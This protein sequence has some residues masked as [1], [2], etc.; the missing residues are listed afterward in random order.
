[1]TSPTFLRN[2]VAAVLV[3]VVSLTAGCTATRRPVGNPSPS[4]SPS[5]TSLLLADLDQQSRSTGWGP[6]D[7][8]NILFVSDSSIIPGLRY[9]WGVLSPQRAMHVYFTAVVAT[10]EGSPVSVVIRSAAD[11]A[12]ATIGFVPSS[13]TQALEACAEGV[14]VTDR[15]RVPRAKPRVYLGPESLRNLP[16]AIGASNLSS[17]RLAAPLVGRDGA[18]GWR[19]SF[20]AIVMRDVRRFDCTLNNA[21]AS[22]NATETM[23]GLG[24][25]PG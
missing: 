20:W 23:P 1:M 7:S 14:H 25:I 6:V 8:A 13:P 9:H 10:R 19:A 11:W 18:G 2:G 17:E 5:V 3:T 12:K 24:Y 15:L 21:G 16:L 22:L 4:S